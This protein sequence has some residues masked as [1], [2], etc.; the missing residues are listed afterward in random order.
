MV[1][2]TLQRKTEEEKVIEETH[3]MQQANG[4]VKKR[5]KIL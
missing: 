1:E 3:E 2:V 4:W 5:W